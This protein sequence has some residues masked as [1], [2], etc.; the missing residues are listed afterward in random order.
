MKSA[1]LWSYA[2]AFVTVAFL[3]CHHSDAWG[4]GGIGDKARGNEVKIRPHL[5]IVERYV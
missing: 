2:L 5:Q 1:I 4:L 3:S